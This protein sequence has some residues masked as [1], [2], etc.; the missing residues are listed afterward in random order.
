MALAVWP[1][2]L[3]RPVAAFSALVGAACRCPTRSF[4]TR[5]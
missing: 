1:A 5:R 3:A 4:S 2:T